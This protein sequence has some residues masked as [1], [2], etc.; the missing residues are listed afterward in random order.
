MVMLGAIGV[1]AKVLYLQFIEGDEWREKAEL[2]SERSQT[3]SANR[4]NILDT[5][6]NPIA[7]TVPAYDLAMDPNSSGMADED[8]RALLPG[9]ANGLENLFG[10]K[11]A[12]QYEQMIQRAREKGERHLVLQKNISYRQAQQA[13]Q[14]PL[15]SL[16]RYKGG[17]KLEQKNSRI[18][19]YERLA[20]RTIG[21]AQ[22][23]EAGQK[24]GL[25]GSFD[26]YLRG[27]DGLRYEYRLG[28][29]DWIPTSSQNIIEPRDGYDILT[30]IDMNYQDVAEQGLLELLE[31]NKADHGCAVLM[32]VATGEIKAMVNLELGSDGE[33]YE[34]Y[35]YAV[36]ERHEPGSTFKLPALMAA[37]EA[38]FVEPDDTINTF[39]GVHRFY[40]TEVKDSHRGGYGIITAQQVLEKS[41]N[42]G[43]ARIIDKYFKDK[44]QQFVDRLYSMGL[45]E[46]TGIELEGEPEPVIRNY[47]DPGWSKISLAFMAHGYEVAL[48]PLQILTFYNAVANDGKMVAPR[49]VKGVKFHSHNEKI[50]GVRVIKNSICSRETINK[51]RKMLEG[52]VKNGT[53]TN[54]EPKAYQIAGK[55]GTAVISQKGSGYKNVQG[56][57]EYRASFVGYFPADKPAYSCIVVV[58]KPKEQYYGNVVA[59]A[60]FQKIAD[61]V[62]A[63]DP[64]LHPDMNTYLGDKSTDI[65]NVM[66]GEAEAARIILESLKIPYSSTGKV[67]LFASVEKDQDK[68]RLNKMELQPGIIPDLM[69]MGLRDALPLLENEGLKVVVNGHGKI[70]SQ[71]VNPGEKIIPGQT[72]ELMLNPGQ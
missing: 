69:G 43:M 1:M 28:G 66:P 18:R 50:F 42:I 46:I 8:Y 53:A 33:Y 40:G 65:P 11:K 7:S 67:G 45:K 27:S 36:A 32:E 68:A 55:T 25:E 15:F 37:M 14:L 12:W 63:T 20:K 47:G 64:K 3:V 57:K 35:N 72:I 22:E 70:I 60:V 4:G 51:A 61:K 21:Y 2:L 71:S 52:V 59:G 23:W 34:S 16:G 9:L 10:D 44:P 38:G 13:K 56:A 39:H 49:L 31:K 30:T 5:E 24:V 58:T 6:G 19:P 29:N 48:T 54:L 41:S 62:Y 26:S 17:I